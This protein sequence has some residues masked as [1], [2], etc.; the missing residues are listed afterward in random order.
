MIDSSGGSEKPCEAGIY[1]GRT[2][3]NSVRHR[4]YYEN[5]AVSFQ[6]N[7]PETCIAG[8]L[9]SHDKVSAFSRGCMEGKRHCSRS[10]PGVLFITPKPLTKALLL[11]HPENVWYTFLYE[12]VESFTFHEE[13]V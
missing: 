3:L 1:S 11:V 9:T 5:R 12:S 7:Q 6:R 13:H 2:G 10:T 8:T 4:E